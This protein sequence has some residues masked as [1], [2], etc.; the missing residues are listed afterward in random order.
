LKYSLCRIE[1]NKTIE[2][3][4]KIQE[5]RNKNIKQTTRT[6]T[7]QTMAAMKASN[8]V[9]SK[10]TLSTPKTLDNGGKMIFLNYDGG[11]SP[12]F[13]QTPEVEI[14]F[15]PSYYSDSDTSGKYQIKFSLKNMEDNP[16][17]KAF[18]DKIQSLDELLKQKAIDNSVPWFKKK[19]M[20]I[21]TI[22][23]L[24]SPM[25]KVSIDAETGEPNGKYPPSFG[26]KVVKKDNK[27]LCTLYDKQKNV[28]D[29][30]KE[31]DS[32]VDILNVLRKGSKIKAV[33]KCNG[34]WLANGKFGCTWRAEQVRA[35]IPE[36]GLKDF[37]IQ[38]DS[39]DEGDEVVN[40]KVLIDDSDEDEVTD[41]KKEE[42]EEDEGVEL[43][44]EDSTPKKNVKKVR[45]IKVKTSPMK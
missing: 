11:M 37:A 27:V 24:Y 38:T 21:D 32:P 34:V 10:I 17:I 30:N 44:R 29:V 45:K 5:T 18:H 31:T 33:L 40:E 25:I 39:E 14:P 19:T 3:K 35:T 36:G 1:I 2:T 6:K 43:T 8:V 26:F 16:D 12:L 23:S 9:L 13:L 28:F 4:Q 42:E 7:T 41:T 22:D 15:D 20:T